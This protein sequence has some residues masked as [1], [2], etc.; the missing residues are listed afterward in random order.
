LAERVHQLMDLDG[1]SYREAA[2]ALQQEGEAVNSGNVW[3]SYRRYYAMRGLPVPNRPY[4]NGRP[5]R[6]A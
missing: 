3:Y 6:R 5:R 2:A 4:N 1:L